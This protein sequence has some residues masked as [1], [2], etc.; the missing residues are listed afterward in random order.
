MKNDDE[1][2]DWRSTGRRRARRVLFESYEPFECEYCKRTVKIPPMDAPPWFDEIWPEE[3]R[4]LTSTLQAQHK[5]KDYE[6]ND[7]S[8]LSWQCASCTKIEDMQTAKGE[9]VLGNKE[10]F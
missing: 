5:M 10:F 6:Q 1:I 8:V 7:L 9:S 2:K 3:R 4:E